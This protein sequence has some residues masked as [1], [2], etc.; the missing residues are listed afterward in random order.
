MNVRRALINSGLHCSFCGL[1][2]LERAKLVA[3]GDTNDPHSYSEKGKKIKRTAYIC[4]VCVRAAFEACFE[5]V[6]NYHFRSKV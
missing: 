5:V 4:N 6:N 2:N 1:S 3:S